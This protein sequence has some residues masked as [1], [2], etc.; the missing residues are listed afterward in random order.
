LRDSIDAI[1]GI[2]HAAVMAD[3]GF[4]AVLAKRGFTLDPGFGEVTEPAGFVGPF[5]AR[6]AQIG[7]HRDRYADHLRTDVL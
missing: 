7:R 6:A 4:R 5:T 2:R 3:P 1:N